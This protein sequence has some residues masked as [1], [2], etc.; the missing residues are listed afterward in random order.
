MTITIAV[1]GAFWLGFYYVADRG[2]EMDS[3][4]AQQLKEE[5][6][7][8]NLSNQ[9]LESIEVLDLSNK[10]MTSIE[11]LGALINLKELNLSGNLITDAM[12]I[13]E[14]EQLKKL[15]V[16]FNQLTELSL[17]SKQLETLNVEANRLRSIAFVS[18]LPELTNLNLRENNVIDLA[19][20]HALT[21]LKKLNIR[22]N[23]VLSLEPLAHMTTLMDLNARNNRITSVEPIRQLPLKKRLYVKGNDIQDLAVFADRLESFDD[24]DFEIPIPQPTFDVQSGLYTEPFELGLRTAKH[25]QIYYTLDGSAPSVKSHR[26]RGP[27]EISERLML[28][29]KM[30][31]N[32]KT[33]PLKEAFSFEPR[34]VKKAITVTAASFDGERLSQTVSH[35][36]IFD[37]SLFD[38][39]LPVI[40]LV[41][42]PKEF[43][44]EDGG[45]YVPGSMYRDGYD[46][47]GNYYQK[48]RQHERAGSFEYFHG[49]GELSFRQQ[50]GLRINGS[51]TRILPQ[52]SLRIYPREEYGQSHMYSKF[53]EDLPYYKF[54]RLVL[55]NSGNDN[56]STMLRDGLMSELIKD[57]SIDVQAYQPAIVLLNG[58]YWGIHNIREKFTDDYI[59][60]KYNVKKSDVVMLTVSKKG[61]L[62]YEAEAGIAKD[63]LHYKDLLSYVHSNDMTKQ[64]H[65]DYVNTQMDIDNFLTYVAY[66][67]YYAN[68]DS[69]SNNMT[70]WRKRVDYTPHA[71]VG[72]DGRWRWMLFDLDWGMG[73]GLLGKEGDP[74]KYNMLAHMTTD[75]EA[76]QLFKSLMDNQTVK[77]QFTKTLLTLLNDNF[78][79]ENVHKKID[80]L[81]AEI[82]PEI[83]KMIAR[84]DNIE[85]V[86]VWEDNIQL[87]HRFADERPD[88][89]RTHL[90]ETFGYT[91]KELAQLIST[92]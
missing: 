26:Y 66:Q 23:E 4:I 56:N 69:F 67:V 74:I 18:D 3:T 5:Y 36:Y 45:I 88:F 81:A 53:F 64:T 41:V 33:S 15:D 73:Y 43:F 27:F 48:G 19:P 91:E 20:L 35:T 60:V 47:T 62:R 39:Q 28:E 42:Q 31:A 90:K 80:E 38:S 34:E 63:S 87:L 11:G 72:H 29:Q 13:A 92:E 82:R 17:A 85:S 86:D 83:P 58:E 46:R 65:V 10:N 25:H 84:W 68:T 37:E 57:S 71:P 55:R 61:H 30:N 14:L 1:I 24:Y 44:A 50:V 89:I 7:T 54:N 59:E 40:S 16:S 78:K 32:E 49:N 6:Q 52:K 77:D 22:G 12:P 76:V 51:Y 79:A 75:E 9:L 2:V 8:E 70:I 21:N